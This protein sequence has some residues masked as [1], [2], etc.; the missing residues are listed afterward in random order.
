MADASRSDQSSK[1]GLH[2]VFIVGVVLALALLDFILQN[3]VDVPIHFLFFYTTQPLWLLLLIT[4][5]L[6][7]AAGEV[8]GFVLRRRRD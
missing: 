5:A 8:F 2:P 6:A 1:L 4:S 3:R 7:I